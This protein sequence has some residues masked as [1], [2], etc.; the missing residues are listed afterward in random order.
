MEQGPSLQVTQDISIH[1]RN[2]ND[3]KSIL[4]F[5]RKMLSPL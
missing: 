5:R 2:S 3:G 4:M 1:S